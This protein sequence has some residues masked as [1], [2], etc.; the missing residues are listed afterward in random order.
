MVKNSQTLSSDQS[1][2]SLK[3]TLLKWRPDYDVAA[4]EYSKAGKNDE[5]FPIFRSPK[6]WVARQLPATPSQGFFFVFSLG[7]VLPFAGKIDFLNEILLT[8][9]FDE[10][11][12]CQANE[13][14]WANVV[15]QVHTRFVYNNWLEMTRLVSHR[16]GQ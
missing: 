2:S 5:N 10:E 12:Q 9:V 16:S 7:Q 14:P 6:H 8:V 3:T 4:D 11:K 1:I 13:Q 15:L